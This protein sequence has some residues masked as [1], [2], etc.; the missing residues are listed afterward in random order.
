VFGA[1]DEMDMILRVAVRDAPEG[2]IKVMLEIFVCVAT[3]GALPAGRTRTQ[4]LRAW[5]RLFRAFGAGV[6]T[7]LKMKDIP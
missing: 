7:N 2:I 6:A 1:E 3:Y 5:A 4:G